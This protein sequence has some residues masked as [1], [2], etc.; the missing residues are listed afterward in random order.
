MSY[1]H[2][3]LKPFQRQPLSDKNSCNSRDLVVFLPRHTRCGSPEGVGGVR[4]ESKRPELAF[5]RPGG[6]Q[7]ASA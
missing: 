3:N 7:I 4:T 5:W 1:F 6:V 2:Y